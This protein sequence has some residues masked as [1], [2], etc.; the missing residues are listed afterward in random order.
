MDN[1][2]EVIR[3]QMDETR[4]ALSE[5]VELLEQQVVETV[6]GATTAV[7][8]TVGSVKE[9]VHDTVQTVKDSVQETV[10]SVKNTLDLQR[11]VEQR[12][13][14][15][16]A[17]ATAVGFLGGCLLRRGGE[18]RT[19]DDRL[20]LRGSPAVGAA[21]ASQNGNG[22]APSHRVPTRSP[23][24]ENGA[25]SPLPPP[26]PSWLAKVGESFEGEITQLKG[27]AVGTLLGIV[28]DMVAKSVPAPL[29][30]QVE[31]V[32]D[33]ITIKLGGHPVRGRILPIETAKQ[34]CC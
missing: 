27:L 2:S 16:M 5:K 7:A 29:E 12:P 18:G 33:G 13:W 11:Q 15:M 25:T 20:H 31:E 30:R 26:Q 21:F 9:V 8:E 23:E 4:S 24:T 32:I 28:R 1:E 3:Q 14:T 17:G 19:N 34:T 22:A 10:D 6:Q